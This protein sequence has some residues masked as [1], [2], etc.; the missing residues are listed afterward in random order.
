MA[1]AGGSTPS[2]LGLLL[3]LVLFTSHAAAVRGAGPHAG[4]SANATIANS[5]TIA[6]DIQ[7]EFFSPSLNLSFPETNPTNYPANDSFCTELG[8]AVNGSVGVVL[9]EGSDPLAATFTG[10]KY[11]ADYAPSRRMFELEVKLQLS[12]DVTLSFPLC[13]DISL[14]LDRSTVDTGVNLTLVGKVPAGTFED[15]T[16]NALD[17]DWSATMTAPDGGATL[18]WGDKSLKD[19][20][21][22]GWLTFKVDMDLES[23]D[24]GFGAKNVVLTPLYDIILRPPEEVGVSLEYVPGPHLSAEEL[25]NRIF[26]IKGAGT[27]LPL[28]A[29]CALY[30][31]EE[32]LTIASWNVPFDF[33]LLTDFSGTLDMQLDLERTGDVIGKA[34]ASLTNIAIGPIELADVKVSADLFYSPIHGFKVRHPAVI[35]VTTTCDLTRPVSRQIEL[36]DLLKI[37][38]KKNL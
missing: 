20:M 3:V 31:V 33:N 37:L 5:N 11:C 26:R 12:G 22:G 27:V 4:S 7:F 28:T 34:T 19:L 18:R 30:D 15:V 21:P 10:T 29:I 23:R 25:M 9:G 8:E 1:M 35:W 32:R 2:R 17:L 6:K 38:K 36:I 24:G 14:E 16:L 13:G